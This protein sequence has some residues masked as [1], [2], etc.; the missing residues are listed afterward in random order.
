[1]EKQCVTYS[2]CASVALDIQ[3]SKRMRRFTLA[4]IV[5]PALQYFT[6]LSHK[7]HE[8]RKTVYWALRVC[9]DFLC[10]FCLKKFSF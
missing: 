3:R 10:N 6:T 4:S 8:F 9:F 2:E 7:M 5:F 1:M